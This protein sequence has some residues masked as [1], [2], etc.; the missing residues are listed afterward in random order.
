MIEE[1]EPRQQEDHTNIH[2]IN[3]LKRNYIKGVYVSIYNNTFVKP[4]VSYDYYHVD[5]PKRDKNTYNNLDISILESLFFINELSSINNSLKQNCY[6]F[7]GISIEG[8]MEIK[9]MDPKN[10][11]ASKVN[12]IDVTC[13]IYIRN[14]KNEN[15][16]LT[17]DMPT[18]YRDLNSNLIVSKKTLSYCISNDKALLIKIEQFKRKFSK[19]SKLVRFFPSQVKNNYKKSKYPSLILDKNKSLCFFINISTQEYIAPSTI[20][21]DSSLNVTKYIKN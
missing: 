9:I 20:T 11:N 19:Y 21:I 7:N 2:E 16:N 15:N 4:N 18:Q 13:G 6:L 17:I 14:D 8:F 10:L 1:Q 3:E 5:D 12:Y